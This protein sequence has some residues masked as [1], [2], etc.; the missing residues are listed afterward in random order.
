MADK[1]VDT[2][3]TFDDASLAT[4]AKLLAEHRQ[5]VLA[6]L[7]AGAP[8]T[9]MVAYAPEPGF[10]GFLLHLSNLSA[11]KQHLRLDPRVSLIVFEPDNGRTE[12]LQHTRVALAC[13][14]AIVAKDSDDYTASKAHYLARFPRHELMFTL[15][16]FDLVRLLP[17]DGLLNAGFGRAYKVTPADLAAAARAA[18]PG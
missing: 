14:A 18:G 17:H 8:Y 5:A 1:S 10:A 16:D 6:T 3:Q 7:D 4:L 13:T 2:F 15:G 9:A 11:H 12:I